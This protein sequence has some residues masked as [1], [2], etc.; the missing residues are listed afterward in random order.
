MPSAAARRLYEDQI[1]T[2]MSVFDLDA[3]TIGDCDTVT[4]LEPKLVGMDS[5]TVLPAPGHDGTLHPD[6]NHK[7]S[8]STSTQMSE[9]TD[10]SP[11]TTLST[12]DSSPLTDRS[13]SSSP[14]SPVNTNLI[15]LN[16]YPGTTFVA[17]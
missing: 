8:D 9:S 10:S 1:P 3:D 17:P 16:N 5:K 2:F 15:P 6:P 14:D 4:V 7:H 13:P 12:T 11:T